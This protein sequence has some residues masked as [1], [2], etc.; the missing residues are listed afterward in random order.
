LIGLGVGNLAGYAEPGQEFTFYEIDPGV[1]AIAR[2]PRYFTYLTDAERRGAKMQVVL[3][4]GRLNLERDRDRRF[5]MIILDAFSDDAIPTHLLTREAFQL[6]KDR[7]EEDGLLALHMTNDHVDLEP[8]VAELAADQK[9]AALIQHDTEVS[10]E[11]RQHGKAPSTWVVL[12]R[13]Q[14][15]FGALTQSNRWRTLERGSASTVWRDDYTN[16]LP[17]V[18]WN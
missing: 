18:K 6:Y 1:A 14:E 13:R 9:L 17:F 15:H 3:G 5:G 8:I 7:L 11:D 2:D 16:L 4:D 12:A 10:P